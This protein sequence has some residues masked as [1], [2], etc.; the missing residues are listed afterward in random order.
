MSAFSPSDQFSHYDGEK[1]MKLAKFYPKDFSDEALNH[2][3]HDLCLYLDNVMNDTW[4]ASLDRISDLAK[5]MV[6]TRKHISYPLVYHLL[7]LV[8]NLHVATTTVERSFLAMKFV[9]SSLL[10]KWVMII[11]SHSLICFVEEILFGQIPN[12]VIVQHFH[13]K[14]HCGMKR[15]VM[16]PSFL[17]YFH[18]HFFTISFPYGTYLHYRLQIRNRIKK[19]SGMHI[20]R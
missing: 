3:E 4:F 16:F 18:F 6:T 19:T 20:K 10:T 12:E 14:N 5:L 7:K 15:K 11:M 1:L 2:L 9:K 17:I 13:A 8:P